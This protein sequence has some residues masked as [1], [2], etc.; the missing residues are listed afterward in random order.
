MEMPLDGDKYDSLLIFTVTGSEQ[1]N[2]ALATSLSSL[3]GSSEERA[4][5]VILDSVFKKSLLPL[6]ADLFLS[7]EQSWETQ[8]RNFLAVRYN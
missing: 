4:H 3:K 1:E 8:R 6:S 2:R 7:L 5:L